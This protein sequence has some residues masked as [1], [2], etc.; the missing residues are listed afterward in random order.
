VVPRGGGEEP[1]GCCLQSLPSLDGALRGRSGDGPIGPPRGAV[2]TGP[3]YEL[4]T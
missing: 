3:E 4:L 2:R 1:H